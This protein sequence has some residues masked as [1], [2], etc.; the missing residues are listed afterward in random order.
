MT[1]PQPAPGQAA[2]EAWLAAMPL[3]PN[4]WQRHWSELDDDRRDRW[5][6]AAEAVAAPLREE[7][8]RLRIAAAGRDR[9]L[10]DLASR[11]E[12]EAAAPRTAVIADLALEGAQ[13]RRVLAAQLREVTGGG[14]EG[15]A[16]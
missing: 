7:L 16:G 11:W 6:A 3:P 9:A 15:G 2:R 5:H 13:V 8:D 10:D 4:M 1:A 12:H 14:G